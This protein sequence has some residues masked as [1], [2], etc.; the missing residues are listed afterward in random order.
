[1]ITPQSSVYTIKQ[2][3]PTI[4]TRDKRVFFMTAELPTTVSS[5]SP[6]CHYQA[7]EKK[8]Y[9]YNKKKEK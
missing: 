7:A 3:L 2:K 4:Q 8:I 9:S 5:S 6:W 1:M